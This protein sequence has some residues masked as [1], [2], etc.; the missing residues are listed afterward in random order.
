MT[1]TE[2]Q[3]QIDKEL[4]HIENVKRKISELKIDISAT[5]KA[6]SMWK[7]MLKGNKWK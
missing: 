6:I 4:H 1:K 2:I 5:K 3:K 7:S